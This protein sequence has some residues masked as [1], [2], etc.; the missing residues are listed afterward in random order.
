MV[1]IS[2]TSSIRFKLVET[3]K[4]AQLVNVLKTTILD[5]TRIYLNR[6]DLKVPLNMIKYEKYDHE[7][8]VL[9]GKIITNH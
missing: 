6:L 9:V 3:L 8:V 4:M 5:F 2:I 1:Q 7:T